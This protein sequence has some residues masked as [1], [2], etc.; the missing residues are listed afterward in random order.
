MARLEPTSAHIGLYSMFMLLALTSIIRQECLRLMATNS[1]AYFVTIHLLILSVTFSGK[2]RVY[3]RPI[4][5]ILNGHPPNL[6][7]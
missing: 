2:V 3:Q 6:S 5:T 1:L 7:F 4:G